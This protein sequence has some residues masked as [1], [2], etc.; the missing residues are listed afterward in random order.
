[1]QGLNL[2]YSENHKYDGKRGMSERII[3]VNL[4]EERERK[5]SEHVFRQSELLLDA[6]DENRLRTSYLNSSV[7]VESKYDTSAERRKEIK[8][9]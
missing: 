4:T 6:N 9:D 7:V 3:H 1:M 2:H 8:K 5:Q